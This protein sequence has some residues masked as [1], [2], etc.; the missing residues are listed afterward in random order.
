MSENNYYLDGR[1]VTAKELRD[2]AEHLYG[3]QRGKL[4]KFTSAAARC[5]RERGHLVKEKKP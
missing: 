5:L 2:E 4:I 1:S 3:Y